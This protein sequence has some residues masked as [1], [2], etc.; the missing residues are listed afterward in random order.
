[1]PKPTFRK[2]TNNDVN[3]SI[4]KF[5]NEKISVGDIRR[6]QLITTFGVGSIVDFKDDTVIIA[7]TDDWDYNPN[8]IDEI[9]NRKIF[10]E[11]LSVITNA[12]YFLMPRTAQ[13]TNS[14]SKG[15]NIAS[16]IFPEKLHCS[17]CGNVYDFRELDVK[18]RHRCPQ[19]KNN[20]NASRFIVV[21][22]HGH[23]DDFPYDWWVHG[24]KPCPSDVKSPRIKMVNI[25]NRTSIDSLRLECTEC[26]ATRSMVQIFSN[27]ALAEFPC[28]CKH[29]HF[30]EP[31][32]RVQYG[33]CNDKMRA[34]LRSASGVYFPIT[35]AALLIPPWSKKVVNC[36]QKNYSILKNVEEDKL[37]YTIRQ[38]VHDQNITDDEIMRS[39][40]AVKISMEQKRKR[41]EL[42]VYEDEYSILP[43]D[44]NENEDNFSSYTATIP[45][46]YKSFFEQIAV[47]DRLTV[48]QA[49]TGFT[50]ITR[51]ET[52][53]V[54]ISQ[55]P[56]PWLPAV[57]LTGE[58]IFIRFNKDKIT[59]WRNAHSSRYK[60]MKKAMD[61][62]KFVNES[63][64]EIY[65]MLHTFAHLFIR[66]ISNVCGYSA[67]SIREK[68]YSEINDKNE[69]KM[70]GVLIYVSSSDSDS[71]LGGLIS[72][73]DNEDVFER[74]MDSMLERAS[75]CSGDPLCISATK[76]GYENLNYAACHDCTLLPETSC[77]SFNCFL[78]RASIVGLPDNQDLGFFK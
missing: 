24:G 28:T 22:T 11:N 27:N 61:D 6:T 33:G 70:C 13:S 12:E 46:K 14:F 9:E 68:I 51:N 62:S 39:W 2:K 40:K 23:M 65:V 16:Y 17:R 59:Q 60:R 50:R 64:S 53:S 52:N 25:Y 38:V 54:P 73:A 75:W 74:I 30:K 63:F 72:V 36:I 19:C 48:T 57:E 32:A 71:S 5:S 78:D 44:E 77:E 56:K 37:V 8:D 58:G 35:K 10:N 45:Q 66:E 29:P 26:K 7:S 47:V 41:S 21:C 43:K 69:V 55:Y 15:K 20:L 67:A 31:Y 34:R 49:F 18:D 1:M 76:Q 42:S 4:S 3:N